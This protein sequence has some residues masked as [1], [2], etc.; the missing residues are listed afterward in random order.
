MRQNKNIERPMMKAVPPMVSEEDLQALVD[1]ELKAQ[2]RAAISALLANSPADQAKVEAWQQQNLLLRA[3]FAPV[4][5]E[6]VP[7]HLSTAPGAL[8]LPAY[9]APPA[10]FQRAPIG[11]NAWLLL[12][13]GLIVGLGIGLALGLWLGAGKAI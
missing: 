1:G 10:R 5:H 9:S 13:A 8:V 4:A 2:K 7:S 11:R 3:A 6:P 12:V